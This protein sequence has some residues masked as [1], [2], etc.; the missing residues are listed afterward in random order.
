SAP[1]EGLTRALPAVDMRALENLARDETIMQ[2]ADTSKRVEILWDA[3][4]LP[5]YRRIAPAQHADIIAAIYKDIIRKGFV[6]EDYMS[7]Q[8]RR[9]DRTD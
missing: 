7:E 2:L 8:V 3:C 6:D 5:D 9:S 1:L 4:A